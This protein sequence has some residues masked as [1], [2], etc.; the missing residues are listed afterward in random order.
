MKEER[1]CIQI[2]SFLLGFCLLFHPSMKKKKPKTIGTCPLCLAE[3]KI[4]A[5]SHIISE[6]NYKVLYSERHQ[7]RSFVGNGT[8][9]DKKTMQMGIREYLLCRECEERL[10]VWEDHAAKKIGRGKIDPQKVPEQREIR[11]SIDY[12]K[13]KL[14][15]MSLI[16]RLAVSSHPNFNIGSLGLVQEKLR[17]ALY[18]GD[19]LSSSKFPFFI[20]AFIAPDRNFYDDWMSPPLRDTFNGKCAISMVIGGLFYTFVSNARGVPEELEHACPRPDC[21]LIIPV[22]PIATFPEFKEYY[23]AAVTACKKH[24]AGQ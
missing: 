9:K 1:K 5:E 10:M 7:L 3:S 11:I 12:T 14:Y 13:F 19:P 20:R 18:A 23:I 21:D 8:V 17:A 24:A 22:R 6:F 15:G 2:I 4:L 16:W